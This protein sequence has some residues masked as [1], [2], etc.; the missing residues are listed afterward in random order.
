MAHSACS[1]VMVKCSGSYSYNVLISIEMDSNPEGNGTRADR[2]VKLSSGSR[3]EPGTTDFFI[4]CCNT[5]GCG[6][7]WSLRL[8]YSLFGFCFFEARIYRKKEIRIKFYLSKAFQCSII[9]A[10][11]TL[12][13]H[14]LIK[15]IKR[16]FWH[17]R[18]GSIPCILRIWGIEPTWNWNIFAVLSLAF[19]I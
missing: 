18:L 6:I 17:F 19:L 7:G 8:K 12:V 1:F 16:P 13:K 15:S 4:S 2:V 5:N 3:G 10:I 11:S 14:K 9:N